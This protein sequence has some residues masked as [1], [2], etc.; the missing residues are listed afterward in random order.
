MAFDLG[1]AA[2]HRRAK[3]PLKPAMHALPARAAPTDG[4]MEAL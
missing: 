4:I 3:L 2:F 1:R